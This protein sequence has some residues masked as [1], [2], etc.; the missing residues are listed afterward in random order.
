MLA[1]IPSTRFRPSSI[2]LFSLCLCFDGQDIQKR[3]LAFAFQSLHSTIKSRRYLAIHARCDFTDL[4]GAAKF[5]ERLTDDLPSVLRIARLVFVIDR[6]LLIG[7]IAM[8]C[9]SECT[10]PKLTGQIEITLALGELCNGASR[11]SIGFHR[12]KRRDRP[13]VKLASSR[14]LPSFFA[15]AGDTEQ[16]QAILP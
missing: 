3:P 4:N 12:Q 16:F 5:I 15:D 9:I 6:E 2:S 11:R 1:M 14:A 10:F 13:L 7:L 8:P